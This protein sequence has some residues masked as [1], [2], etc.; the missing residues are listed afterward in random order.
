MSG[1]CVCVCVSVRPT[2]CAMNAVTARVKRATNPG[3]PP[4]ALGNNSWFADFDHLPVAS[5]FGKSDHCSWCASV[6]TIC[7]WVRVLTDMYV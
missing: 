5:I 1:V 6:V 7:V 2:R 3:A 4:E